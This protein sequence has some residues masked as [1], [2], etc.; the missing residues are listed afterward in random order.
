[1]L[2]SNLNTFLYFCNKKDRK[3]FYKNF[4][5]HHHRQKIRRNGGQVIIGSLLLF[6][7]IAITVLVGI[8][9]P[10]AIQVRSAAD[11]LQ[12]KQGYIA[13][14]VLN[15][16]SLYRLNK[17]W[18]LPSSIVLS[19][20]DST[21]TAL[22]SDVNGK[23]QV[24]ATGVSGLFSRFSQSVF[25]Q[26][27]DNI[28]LDYGAQASNGGV[29]MEGS[30]TIT[31]NVISNGNISGSGVSTIT[32]NAYAS[33]ASIQT[34][35]QSNGSGIP[36]VNTSFGTSNAVQDFAQSF[37]VSTTTSVARVMLYMKKNGN[38]SSSATL[39]IVTNSNGSPSGTS[40]LSANINPTQVS[41]SYSWVPV[42][43]T[44]NVSLTPGTTYWIV[45]NMP[46]NSSSN[47]YT[48]GVSNTNSYTSGSIKLGRFNVSN[49]WTAENANNDAF[50]QIYLGGVSSISGV[51]VNGN[52]SAYMVNS[53]TIGGTLSC[54]IGTGNNKACNTSSSTPATI[55]YPFSDS[56]ITSWKSEGSAGATYNGNMTIGG[57]TATTTGP[58][59]INGN[60]IVTDSGRLTLSGTV[61]VTGDVTIEG[62][63]NLRLDSSYGSR[64]GVL[65]ADGKINV[66][67]SGGISGS[68]T[69]GS[70]VVF[71]TTSSC[72]GLTTC[73]GN[74]PAITISGAAGAVVL[75]APN[76]KIS[77]EGSASAKAAASYA[78][79]LSGA[80]TINYESGLSNV[81]VSSGGGSGSSSWITDT[82]KEISQ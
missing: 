38:P 25:T 32:G 4:Y 42:A 21:S 12:S 29:V 77:F 55:T 64:S 66:G 17:G 18:S 51:V 6:L 62:A 78:L 39:N 5:I 75:L 73:A 65:V 70:Y 81:V 27:A 26:E 79:K 31:G 33:T 45:A 52:A 23:K 40:L 61:Y 67:G 24:L 3:N 48:I 14:D 56:N 47:Y 20:N 60:L 72:G 50:F 8:A 44:S 11:F 69:S 1:M 30:P 2:N 53:S 58:I 9:T 34:T 54:Q 74:L 43:F 22:I 59:K 28:R 41:T 15:E 63:A 46:S 80:T 13:A 76:G 7:T 35:D 49:S 16:E 68:G 71:V 57:V 10:V 82:W 19:F 37:T 36:A